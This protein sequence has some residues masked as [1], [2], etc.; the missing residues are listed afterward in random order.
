RFGLTATPTKTLDLTVNVSTF[1]RD[2]Q[3]PWSGSFGQSSTVTLPAPL[4]Q[5]T[6]ELN[7]AA[8]WGSGRGSLRLQYDGSWFNNNVQTLEWDNPLRAVDSPTAGSSQG[9][10]ALWPSS[11]MNAVSVTGTAGLPRRS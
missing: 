5:R 4:D 7:A 9:R 3:M 8:E 10:A 6:T 11:T 2:G 1:R